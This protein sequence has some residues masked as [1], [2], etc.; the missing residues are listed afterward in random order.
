MVDRSNSFWRGGEVQS[1]LS[2]A[3]SCNL[4]IPVTHTCHDDPPAMSE[5]TLKTQQVITKLRSLWTRTRRCRSLGVSLSAIAAR[6]VLIDYKITGRR[7]G[8]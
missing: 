3:V 7:Q 5:S 2:L 1:A 6:K 8:V 4:H